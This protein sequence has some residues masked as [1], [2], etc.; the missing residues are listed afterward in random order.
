MLFL[1]VVQW[2]ACLRWVLILFHLA[3]Y[4][5]VSS[6]LL[7]ASTETNPRSFTRAHVHCRSFVAS[8]RWYSC[9]CNLG[10]DMHHSRTC[11]QKQRADKSFCLLCILC[12]HGQT[13]ELHLV[14]FPAHSFGGDGG[15]ALLRSFGRLATLT[16]LRLD[17]CALGEAAGVALGDMLA[18]STSLSVLDLANCAFGEQG[19]QAMVAGVG[20]VKQLKEL[21]LM[22]CGVGRDT[23]AA[24]GGLLAANTPQ[25]LTVLDLSSDDLG[26]AGCTAIVEG[27][28]SNRVVSSIALRLIIP[29]C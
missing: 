3:S 13:N 2:V 12:P 25:T 24:L 14:V 19:G 4:D 10:T 20:K 5:H 21:R 22:R 23:A 1:R 7:T 8:A 27:L 16:E 11:Q 29:A 9:L 18:E 17:S 15:C 26:E 6:S 28:A